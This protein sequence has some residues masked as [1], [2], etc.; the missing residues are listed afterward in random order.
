MS[1]VFDFS[2]VGAFRPGGFLPNP[3]DSNLF[4]SPASLVD[5][6][7][8]PR[9]RS[10]VSA[11][12]VVSGEPKKQPSIEVLPDECLFEVFRRLPAG[13]QER[14]ACASVSKRWLMLLSSIRRD[15][16]CTPQVAQSAQPEIQSKPQKADD[17]SELKE[18]CEFSEVGGIKSD[19]EECLETA[20]GCLSRCLEG[21]KATD[22][23]LASIAVGTASRG[24]LGK[25]SIR[26]STST[27]KL[28]NLGLKAISHG[29]PSLRVLSL[30]N[31][32]S[33]SDEGLCDIANGCRSLEK[34]DL[35]HCPAVSDKGL[36]AIAM[37]CPNLISVTVES[38]SNIGNES[39]QALGRF[40]PNLKCVTIKNCPFVG[41]QGIA[42]LFTSA[43]HIVTKAKLEALNI[44]DV[45]LAVIG[46]YGRAMTDLSLVGL[47][48]VNE[49]GFWVMGKG[50][51]LQKLRSLSITA[52]QGASD[53]GV[54]AVGEGCPDLKLFTLR[55]CPRVSDHGIVSFAKAAG[56]LENL[57]IE[58]C[59][60]IT[61]RGFFGILAN[62]GQK[63]KA[64]A[65]A[66]C[67]GIRD[68][69]FGFPLTSGCDSL[70]SLTIRNCPGFGDSGLGMLGRICPK[71]THVDLSGLQSITD[72]GIVPLVQSSEAGLVKVNLSK[73]V[74]LSD[75]AVSAIAKLH[76]ETLELLNLDGCRYI[77]DTSLMEIAG[78]CFSLSEL[79]VSQSGITDS[80]ITVLAAAEQ[81]NLQIFSVSGCSLVSDKSLPFL[82]ALGKTLVGLNIQHCC[83][84]S[85]GTTSLLLDQLWRC[86]ILY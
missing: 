12:F 56:S 63:L 57:Q 62:C 5:L 83:G 74:N 31:L 40:C 17:S 27:R 11:P 46:H 7:L 22:V 15:E 4:L 68:L 25:L 72:A 32:S 71:L 52:C 45:S 2:D 47:Q 19:E 64:L 9:K 18:K 35:C 51:G 14:S 53:L 30:W 13:G 26:G 39:L 23:R 55:K 66:N 86:D 34:L 76:G 59:H 81:M 1:E 44:T 80:G 43:G 20:H 67:L 21:K 50:Q 79:D 70:R 75:N 6:Y 84:I 41:D 61:Q 33:I 29:S 49:R 69:N 42:S 73:C 60:M 58:E 36:I 77:T 48:N 28:T 3:K 85:F 24:G 54:Q 38:C 10:R 78:N 82:V 16:I 37:N 65:L 8:L